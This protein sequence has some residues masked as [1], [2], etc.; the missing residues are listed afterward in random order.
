MEPLGFKKL[1]RGFDEN[2]NQPCIAKT[3]LGDGHGKFA[4]KNIS[5]GLEPDTSIAAA[6][7]LTAAPRDSISANDKNDKNYNSWESGKF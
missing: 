2:R 4:V 1:E 5:L 3:S 7:R 6:G